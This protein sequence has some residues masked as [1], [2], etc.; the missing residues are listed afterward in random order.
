MRGC[1]RTLPITEAERDF[2]RARGLEALEQRFMDARLDFA[3]PNRPS[4]A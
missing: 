2:T 3:D 1:S 4:V